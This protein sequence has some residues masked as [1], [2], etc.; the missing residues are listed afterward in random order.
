[1]HGVI[2]NDVTVNNILQAYSILK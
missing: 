1:M 2:M